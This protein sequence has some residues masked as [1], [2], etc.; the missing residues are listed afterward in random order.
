LL[1]LQ[2]ANPETAYFNGNKQRV[3]TPRLPPYNE[4]FNTNAK[5]TPSSAHE[6]VKHLTYFNKNQSFKMTIFTGSVLHPE[7]SINQKKLNHHRHIWTQNGDE[8]LIFYQKMFFENY[9]RYASG[10]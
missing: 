9:L 6:G 8:P 10:G 7:S 1:F 2:K 5:K 4:N 3:L